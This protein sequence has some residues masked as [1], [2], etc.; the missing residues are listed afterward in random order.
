[1]HGVRGTADV[2]ITDKT[3]WPFLA[4]SYEVKDRIIADK[5]HIR[6]LLEKDE[7]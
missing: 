2:E 7:G 1:L 6:Q 5:E 3:M 4:T